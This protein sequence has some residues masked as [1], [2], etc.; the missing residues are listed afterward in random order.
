[1]SQLMQTANNYQTSGLFA[2]P[3]SYRFAAYEMDTPWQLGN[4]N[5]QLMNLSS[6]YISNWGAASANFGVMEMYANSVGC[7]NAACTSGV[8]FNDV[9]TDYDSAMSSINST[10]PN[11]GQGTNATGDKPQEVLFFVTD[12]VE[13]EQNVVRLIQP[14]N[15]GSSTNYCTLIKN[16]GI[17]IAVLYT[18]YLPVPANS[19][20]QSYVAPIQPNLGPALQACAS[21]NLYYDAK[22]G[23]D[24]GAAL[25]TLFQTVVQS[26]A[27]SR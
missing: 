7:A 2:T 22:I 15:G 19:F 18:E 10:M 12:G 5:Q 20:Y 4:S 27:L 11:P 3:P 9:A 8:G 6:N 16:R 17:K 21:P 23:D 1:V 25:G 24:L 14:I 26:A 13:D